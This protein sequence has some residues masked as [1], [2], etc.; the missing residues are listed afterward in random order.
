MFRMPYWRNFPVWLQLV[1]FAFMIFTFFY[2]GDSI[3]LYILPKATGYTIKEILTINEASPSSLVR[4]ALI[5]QGILHICIFLLPS[6]LFG[7]MTTPRP[8]IYLGLRKPG[9]PVQWV[10][11]L[12][13]TLGAIPV[14]MGLEGLFEG[15]HLGKWADDA[16]KAI[17]KMEKPFFNFTSFGDFIKVFAILAL[18]PAIGEE[19]F[20]RGILMRFMKKRSRNMIYPI[21]LSGLLFAIAHFTVYGFI[22]IFM[23]GI[24]LGT[25]YYL[26]GSIWCSM[27]FHLLNNGLQL[28]IV[29]MAHDNVT[30][31]AFMESNHLPFYIPVTGAIVFV[32]SFYLLWKNKT[33]LPP[34]WAS[35][36]TELSKKEL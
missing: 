18:L 5:M 33:P 24:L 6:L 22:P 20:F 27:L 28:I 2:F 34:Q 30:I 10:L 36:Y 29:Y 16:Q 4:A 26:T 23:A 15:M 11:V 21:I 19:L 17:E 31:R 25:I 1:L 12:L 35:D 14:L 13:I 9:K 8:A 3:C 32:I 7:Y